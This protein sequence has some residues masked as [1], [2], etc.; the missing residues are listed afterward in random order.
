MGS[1]LYL[2]TEGK[3]KKKKKNPSATMSFLIPQAQWTSCSQSINIEHGRTRV[4]A[5][6]VEL[7]NRTSLEPKQTGPHGSLRGMQNTAHKTR[8]PV[9]FNHCKSV[10]SNLNLLAQE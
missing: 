7:R 1:E 9:P 10:R 6:P 8:M 2:T 4:R 5:I 3:R